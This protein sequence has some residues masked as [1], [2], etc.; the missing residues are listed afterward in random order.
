LEY[1]ETSKFLE[2]IASEYSEKNSKN[3]F[4]NLENLEQFFLMLGVF[5][6]KNKNFHGNLPKAG[7]LRELDHQQYELKC[8]TITLILHRISLVKLYGKKI[9]T[10]EVESR[11]KRV[12]R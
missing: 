12:N 2:I 7:R 4:K 8:F 1:F 5:F 9:S 3:N 6:S 11:L 10:M